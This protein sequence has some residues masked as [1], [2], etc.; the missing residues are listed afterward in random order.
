MSKLCLYLHTHW[1]REWYWSFEKYRTQLVS[2]ARKV[3]EDLESG[4]LSS[5]HL[6]GQTSAVEDILEVAPE[7]G[8]RLKKLVK[9]G[10]LSVG[11]W[12]VLADQMLVS[13]ESLVRNLDLGLRQ[14]RRLGG[15]M[16]VGYCPDTFGH[17][18]DMPRVLAGFGIKTAVVWRGVPLLER[19]PD[20]FWQAPD[21]S[22][23][24]ACLLPDG[25]YQT[26]FHESAS[27][28]EEEAATLLAGYLRSFI[29]AGKEPSSRARSASTLRPTALVPV[30][31]DHL[32]PPADFERLARLS[33][34]GLNGSELAVVKLGDYLDGA[35]EAATAPGA[36]LRIIKGE[37]RDNRSA[38]EHCRAFML[39]GVLSTRLYLKRQNRLGEWRLS[40]IAEP[41]LSLL[42]W[43]GVVNYPARELDH[44]WRLLLRNQPHDSI[45]GCSVDEVHREMLT[46][47]QGLH[48]VLDVLDRQVREELISPGSHEWSGSREA[49]AGT[50]GGVADECG[51]GRL[52]M[53]LL[54]PDA[55]VKKMAVFNLS[56][57]T[58]SAPVPFA[59]AVPP[60]RLGLTSD[61]EPL[62]IPLID[63]AQI[64]A[65]EESIEDLL[66]DSGSV[67][68]DSLSVETEV[69]G[70]ISKVPLYKDICLAR[71][72]I[73][74]G[75]VPAL[76]VCLLSGRTDRS[77]PALAA[78]VD[79]SE[80]R[81]SNG[82]FTVSVDEGGRVL[83]SAAG[84]DDPYKSRDYELGLRFRDQGDGGDSYNF[85][86]VYGDP[87]PVARFKEVTAGR[88][89]PLSGSLRLVHEIDIPECVERSLDREFL[90]A[91]GKKDL[92]DMPALARSKRLVRH[93]IHTE[94]SLRRGVPLVFFETTWDNQS[95]DHR[96][97][98]VFDTGAPVTTTWSENHFSLVERKIKE[99]RQELPVDRAREAPLDRFACQRFFIANQQVFLNL[100][101]PEYGVDG[102]SVSYTIL[103][104]IS[105]LSRK[106]LLTRGGGAGPHILT[107][108]GNCLGSNKVSYGWAPLPVASGKALGPAQIARAYE[109]AE[110]FEGP[111]WMSPFAAG[112][113]S[114]ALDPG[115]GQFR[116]IALY[117]PAVRL[118][119]LF[120]PDGGGSFLLRLL[121]TVEIPV[122]CRL[123]IFLPHR[124]VELADLMGS[125]Q[126]SL[127]PGKDGGYTLKFDSNELLTLK[128]SR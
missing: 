106:R 67:Q 93:E 83:V 98:V 47:Y 99:H 97:E 1:D 120:S 45:C 44:A 49:A 84:E 85:D 39:A 82:Y 111:L 65:L 128:I 118:S 68:I 2:V 94:I 37:L 95:R 105:M 54:D 8:P 88:P 70:S 23:V 43:S 48:D 59:F 101:L 110:L 5:F 126:K 51:F 60:E 122:Q 86:P 78:I 119:A 72:W 6:D 96:L 33:K 3:I 113:S 18:Q 125:R 9:K 87:Q 121:N 31:G 91:S 77:T 71:G 66:G 28:G 123:E 100:G 117:N 36:L 11:P 89:G 52:H 26:A 7:L 35:L 116:A 115:Q 50:G 32:Y 64:G 102:G 62:E 25:Y 24:L 46:R 109:L 73:W 124:K 80:R 76:S 79:R 112:S 61:G 41:L 4:A 69:F 29:E 90:D 19:G 74:P 34:A 10:S 81:L 38:K 27:L 16:M 12:Y 75:A 57:S 56:G 53:D 58:V 108:D 103:R 40:R 30:G 14:S 22:K 21:G 55:P 127:R 114:M 42:A 20:F 63:D 13:G 104:A 15:A 107:P 17:T 92:A